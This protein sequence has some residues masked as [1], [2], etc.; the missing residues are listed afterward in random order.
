M[1]DCQ[2]KSGF[3][4][5]SS[6]TAR[7]GILDGDPSTPRRMDG[8]GTPRA[9]D[10]ACV[11]NGWAYDRDKGEELAGIERK[12]MKKTFIITCLLSAFIGVILGYLGPYVMFAWHRDHGQFLDGRTVRQATLSIPGWY[13]A[14][15]LSGN[16]FKSTNAWVIARHQ[17]AFWNGIAY[18]PLGFILGLG[19][20][21]IRRLFGRNATATVWIRRNGTRITAIAG[22][23][24]TLFLIALIC[25]FIVYGY[26]KRSHPLEGSVLATAIILGSPLIAGFQIFAI[27]RTIGSDI[28]GALRIV[29]L[30]TNIIGLLIGLFLTAMFIFFW[31][32]GPIGPG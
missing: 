12:P 2:G 18:L 8:C 7:R 11:G 30:T 9:R 31:S 6:F 21:L 17:I 15:K 3:V 24:I 14:S 22:N 5:H 1:E 4:G 27:V 20:A 28:G 10:T 19:V 29:V 32:M 13:I 23:A 16:G 25:S 26:L